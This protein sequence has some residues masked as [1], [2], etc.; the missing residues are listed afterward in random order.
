MMK[1]GYWLDMNAKPT[2]ETWY[3]RANDPRVEV[4]S[5][6]RSKSIDAVFDEIS[7]AG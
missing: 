5:H 2:S 3:E 6:Y 7:K 4:N 1:M